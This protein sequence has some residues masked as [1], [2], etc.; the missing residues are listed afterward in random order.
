MAGWGFWCSCLRLPSAEFSPIWSWWLLC[1]SSLFSFLW[2]A[3]NVEEVVCRAT[4]VAFCLL[5]IHSPASRDPGPRQL[6]PGQGAGRCWPLSDWNWLS[7]SKL[8]YIWR[9]AQKIKLLAA[10]FWAL[11]IQV[12]W[13]VWVFTALAEGLPFNTLWKYTHTP[14][15][16]ILLRFQLLT[17]PENIK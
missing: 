17:W 3:Y 16:V 9:K 11:G 5:L 2:H 8:F 14:L 12:T 4:A 1:F 10:S 13:A 7:V 6:I 15:F